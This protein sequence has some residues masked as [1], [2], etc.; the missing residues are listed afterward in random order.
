MG[1]SWGEAVLVG[2]GALVQWVKLPPRTSASP[3]GATVCPTQLPD[4][5][6]STCVPAPM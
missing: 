1:S 2:M 5:D 6:P 4:D 3:M